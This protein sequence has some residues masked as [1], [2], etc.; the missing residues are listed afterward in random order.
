[1]K[2]AGQGV[3]VEVGAS[4]Q[5]IA[6][7]TSS[8]ASIFGRVA[9]IEQ[10]IPVHTCNRTLKKCG[11]TSMASDTYRVEKARLNENEFGNV[12]WDG[13]AVRWAVSNLERSTVCFFARGANPDLLN[14]TD[15]QSTTVKMRR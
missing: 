3:F 12:C 11:E 4:N 15:V 14:R 8:A 9:I 10:A 2:S 13:N 1:M 7:P 6:P 5:M